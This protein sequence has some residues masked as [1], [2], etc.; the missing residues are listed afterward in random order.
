MNTV[1]SFGFKRAAWQS[2][3]MLTLG[4]WL[5]AS[6]LLD[7]V[8]MPSLYVSGMITQAS[9]ATAGYVIFWNFNRIELL[10]AGLVLTGVLALNQTQSKWW[11]GSLVLSILLLA[12][13]LTTTYWLTPE[14][15]AIGMQLNLFETTAEV[16]GNMNLL[17]GGYWLLEVIKLVAGGT[18]LSWCWR[19]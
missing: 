6:L 7:W 9:F 14:M 5:S 18:L 1:S 3:V 17:H 19:Q 15:S 2:I 10:A 4:F 11:S 8:I 12:I 13:S 16:P